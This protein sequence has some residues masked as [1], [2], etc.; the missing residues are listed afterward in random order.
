MTD[1]TDIKINIEKLL[2]KA[3]GITAKTAQR[4]LS[5]KLV[6]INSDNELKQLFSGIDHVTYLDFIIK[7]SN[8]PQNIKDEIENL[9]TTGPVEEVVIEEQNKAEDSNEKTFEQLNKLPIK[10]QQT[11]ISSLIQ[12]N[13]NVNPNFTKIYNFLKYFLN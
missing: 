1:K 13:P 8:A 3:K 6:E 10:S 7:N 12:S 2:N 9:F 11:A 5:S 4:F